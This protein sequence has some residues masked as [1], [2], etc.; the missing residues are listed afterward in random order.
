MRPAEPARAACCARDA[1]P[2]SEGGAMGFPYRRARAG[3]MVGS[4]PDPAGQQAQL[5]GPAHATM[6][7]SGA[8]GRKALCGAFVARDEEVPWP[9]RPEVC[10]VLCADCSELALL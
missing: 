6:G 3:V 2:V 9:P 8:R 4:W 5:I 10:D 1:R 7:L